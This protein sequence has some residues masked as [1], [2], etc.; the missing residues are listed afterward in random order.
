ML[1]LLEVEIK[2]FTFKNISIATTALSWARSDNSIQATS[3]ELVIQMLLNLGLSGAFSMLAGYAGGKLLDFSSFGVLGSLALT[4]NL[5]IVGL[6]PLTE[7]GGVD[8]HNGALNQ[9]LGTDQLV[10][11]GIVDDIDDTG[12]A[13]DSFTTP[14][15]VARIKTESTVFK[16]TTTGTDNVDALRSCELGAGGLTAKFK[17]ALLAIMSAFG[18]CCR[19]F[20][21]AVTTN[22]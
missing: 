1:N 6:P 21:A 8:L 11:A 4:Q 7:W 17:L 15:K 16:V 3:V 19:S 5:S 12:L 10:V 9:G 18:S 2:L 20:M 14:G 22:S 13:G